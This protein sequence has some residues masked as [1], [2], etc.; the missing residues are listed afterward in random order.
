MILTNPYFLTKSKVN[1]LIA[2]LVMVLFSC[3]SPEKAVRKE[4]KNDKQ[5]Q[6][7][8]A[9]TKRIHETFMEA[10]KQ[11]I[12]GNVSKAIELFLVCLNLDEKNSACCYELSQLYHGQGKI[13]ESLQLAK[14]ACDLEPSNSWYLF[15]YA[16]IL[17]Q[18]QQYKLAAEYYEKLSRQEPDNSIFLEKLAEIHLLQGKYSE[19]LKNYDEYESKYGI[20]EIIVVQKQK[21]YLLLKKYDKALEEIQKL[22]ASDPG[23]IR[24][25]SMLAETYLSVGMTD[26][27]METYEKILKISPKDPYVHMSLCDYYN[28]MGDTERAYQEMIIAF[29]NPEMDIDFK[30]QILLTSFAAAGEDE[31]ARKDTYGLIEAMLRA[32]PNEA[33]AWSVYGDFLYLN[34]KPDEARDAYRKVIQID[35][36]RYAI[37]EQLLRID[38]EK[39]D[40]NALIAE[41]KRA[42]DLF[43]EQP[44][45]FYLY[46]SAL[47]Q[48]KDY[49]KAVDAFRAGASLVV[50]NDVLEQAFYTLLGDSYNQLKEH[51]KSDE[52]YEKALRIKPDDPYVLNNYSYYLSLRSEKLE[53]AE[54]MAKRAN[55]IDPGNDSYLDTYAWVLY[56]LNRLEEA[57]KLVLQ[58]IEKG[59]NNNAVI[60]E[61]YGDILFKK[62]DQDKALEQWKKAKAAGKGSDNLDKKISD[63]NLYE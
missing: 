46:G 44:I 63:K 15:L 57:E 4:S 40:Y 11:K 7:L 55:E 24:Y 30:V 10:N 49:S 45:P 61:H 17:E 59:G 23:E 47:F 42:T 25:L 43:P 51:A 5:E 16:Q 27:A 37:W 3:K 35:S 48:K 41:G 22:V 39:E 2:I 6:V 29:E 9:K 1:I 18:T 20:D 62:G 56:K 31:A 36:S 28:K 54:K 58:A 8:D 50:D 34:Q 60:L 13:Q 33:K 14:K 53:K 38:S 32:H 26:K 19:A 21:I 12:L 52:S